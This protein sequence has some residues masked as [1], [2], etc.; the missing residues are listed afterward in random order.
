MCDRPLS[1]ID[2]LKNVRKTSGIQEV[3][4]SILGKCKG[5][6]STVASN[7]YVDI[8][9]LL[10]CLCDSV[11]KLVIGISLCEAAQY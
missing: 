9:K 4:N 7:L 3:T 5:H 10:E 11:F 2:V 8:S 1:V 6:L